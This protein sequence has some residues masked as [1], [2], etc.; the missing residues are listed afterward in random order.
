MIPKKYEFLL[1]SLLM[2]TF[3]TFI[4]SGVVSYINIGLEDDFLKIWS[5]AFV[6]AFVVA[7]PSVMI[8][9]PIV[10]KLVAKLLVS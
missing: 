9:V 10:R 4:M 3:M 7:F 6:N 1:F 2:S 5:F 8:V